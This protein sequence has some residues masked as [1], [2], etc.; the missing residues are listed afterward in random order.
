MGLTRKGFQMTMN[1]K[2]LAETLTGREIVEMK[3]HFNDLEAKRISLKKVLQN[4]NDN[5]AELNTPPPK[6]SWWKFW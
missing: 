3:L 5:V 4:L 1:E 2:E 6:K